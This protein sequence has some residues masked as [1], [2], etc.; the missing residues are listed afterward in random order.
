MDKRDQRIT[1]LKKAAQARLDEV[2][3]PLELE[4]GADEFNARFEKFRGRHIKNL[5]SVISVGG[6]THTDKEAMQIDLFDDVMELQAIAKAHLHSL[7]GS[8]S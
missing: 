7:E 8:E 4:T 1:G 2:G 6:L 3:V 5:T